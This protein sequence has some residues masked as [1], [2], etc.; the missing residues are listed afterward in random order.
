MD[1]YSIYPSATPTE[2]TQSRSWGPT[3]QSSY[4]SEASGASST[5]FQQALQSYPAVGNTFTTPITTQTPATNT[6]TKPEPRSDRHPIDALARDYPKPI[7][8]LDVREA[9][10][11]KPGRWTLGHYIKETPV[12]NFEEAR[13]KDKAR[14]AREQQARKEELTRAKE[15]LRKMALPM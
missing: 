11:R 13:E 7:K 6:E 12:L 9:L 15:E 1:T 14:V 2:T 5:G 4:S 10:N 3:R 8:E